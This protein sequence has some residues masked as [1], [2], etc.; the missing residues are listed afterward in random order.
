MVDC[1]AKGGP[2]RAPPPDNA[3]YVPSWSPHD[4]QVAFVIWRDGQYDVCLANADG[5]GIAPVASGPTDELN[6]QWSPDGGLITYDV[7]SGTSWDIGAYECATR[8]SRMLASGPADECALGWSRA[9]GVLAFQRL[10]E[11]GDPAGAPD[12]IDVPGGFR[13]VKLTVSLYVPQT[14]ET[15]DLPVAPGDLAG[16]RVYEALEAAWAPDGSAIALCD[17]VQGFTGCAVVSLT[18]PGL[19][20]FPGWDSP[21]WSP[22][23]A[24]LVAVTSDRTATLAL[25]ACS[26]GT[27]Q[28]SRLPVRPATLHVTPLWSP[29]GDLIAVDAIAPEHVKDGSLLSSASILDPSSGHVTFLCRER[30]TTTGG[31]WSPDGSLI[32]YDSLD[33]AGGGPGVCLADRSGRDLRKL[34]D[35]PVYSTS[36]CWSPDGEFIAYVTGHNELNSITGPFDTVVVRIDGSSSV[37]LAALVAP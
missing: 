22:D 34:T 31:Q 19:R 37:N 16:I 12:G 5:T 36:R 35:E 7:W 15:R 17:R 9:T 25:G 4:G 23:S 18:P 20:L 1:A 32:A 2:F 29:Q 3:V 30:A 6:P 28:S 8:T 27:A 24:N 26:L 21:S 13:R 11:P 14:G 10:D 33:E